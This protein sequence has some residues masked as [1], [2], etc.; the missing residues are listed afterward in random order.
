MPEGVKKSRRCGTSG[1]GLAG[2]VVLGWRLDLM[3]LEVFSKL[4]DSMILWFHLVCNIALVSSDQLPWLRPLPTFSHFQPMAFGGEKDVAE[5]ALMLWDHCSAVTNTALH[6]VF[7][8]P[9]TQRRGE[10]CSRR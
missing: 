3:I 7:C 1:H 8:P 9:C 10:T 2:M 5:M 6:V 4:N